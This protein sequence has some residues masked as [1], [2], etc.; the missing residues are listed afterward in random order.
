[1]KQLT[2][3]LNQPSQT[4]FPPSRTLLASK[5]HSVYYSVILVVF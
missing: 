1:M 4:E 3:D 5:N 2:A